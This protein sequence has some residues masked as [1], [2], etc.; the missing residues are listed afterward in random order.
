MTGLT[1]G[2]R[3]EVTTVTTLTADE[4]PAWPVPA[5]VFELYGCMV[6]TYTGGPRK[7]YGWT[8]PRGQPYG[9]HS[10]PYSNRCVCSECL[11]R[12]NHAATRVR[13]QVHGGA[14]RFIATTERWECSVCG[15]KV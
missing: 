9:D 12:D 5:G 2:M 11:T 14:G 1:P 3:V 13:D 8:G 7:M 6:E 15:R 10:T 4:A